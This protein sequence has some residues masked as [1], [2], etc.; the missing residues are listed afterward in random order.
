MFHNN[1][2]S[3]VLLRPQNKGKQ[4]KLKIQQ[5]IKEVAAIAIL[6]GAHITGI[7][8]NPKPRTVIYSNITGELFGQHFE[9]LVG[10]KRLSPPQLRYKAAVQ[11]AGIMYHAD[12][13]LNGFTKWFDKYLKSVKP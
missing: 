12:N 3:N 7:K 10:T 8:T 9:L 1:H 13:D 2:T 4:K 11:N 6:N 5:P